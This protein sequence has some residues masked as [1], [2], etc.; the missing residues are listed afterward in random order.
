MS[1]VFKIPSLPSVH[2]PV[3]DERGKITK[4]WLRSFSSLLQGPQA[5]KPQTPGGSPYSFTAPAAGSFIVSGG[6]VSSITLTRGVVKPVTVNLGV[7]AGHFP[8]SMGDVF[9]ITY[10]VAPTVTFL[11]G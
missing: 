9:K 3:V 6:T 2:E 11:P 5:A 1:T 8:A 10:T 7:V 4:A